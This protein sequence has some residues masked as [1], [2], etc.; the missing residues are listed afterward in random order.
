MIDMGLIPSVVKT[1]NL[2]SMRTWADVRD[3]VR[4]YY[5]LVTVSKGHTNWQPE[6][7]FEKKMLDLLDYWR[8]RTESGKV[9]LTRGSARTG[10]PHDIFES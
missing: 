1:G 2:Q 6:I 7:Q 3:A 9:F 4:A 10:N 8:E 5:R